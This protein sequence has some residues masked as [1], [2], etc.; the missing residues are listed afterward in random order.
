MLE[1]RFGLVPAFK[2]PNDVLVEGKKICGVLVE[3]K[4]RSNGKLESLVI[5]I[6]LNV[7]ASPRRGVSGAT[8]LFE[9]TGKRQSRSAILHA[10][11]AEL[12]RDLKEW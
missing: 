3:A 10:L 4:G 6:G 1:K 7:N 11:L 8:S 12:N 2:R 9:E 5:G